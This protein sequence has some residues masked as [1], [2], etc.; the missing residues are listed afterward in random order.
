[1]RY[2]TEIYSFFKNRLLLCNSY[3]TYQNITIKIIKITYISYMTNDN[4]KLFR[5]QILKAI[6][7]NI[8]NKR[9]KDL[10]IYS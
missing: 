9:Q 8:M 6:S 5:S 3:K 7:N 1:M 10:N 4:F 2:I